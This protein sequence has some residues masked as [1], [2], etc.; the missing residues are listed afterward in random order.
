M[1]V[2]GQPSVYWPLENLAILYGTR[3]L[4]MALAHTAAFFYARYLKMEHVVNSTMRTYLSYMAAIYAGFFICRLLLLSSDETAV[5]L[6][7]CGDDIM[8]FVQFGIW[9][10]LAYLTL[11]R[12][13]QYWATDL[14]L[15]E[16]EETLKSHTESITWG[17]DAAKWNCVIPKTEIYYRKTLEERMD[18]SVELHFW[19]RRMVI[20]KRF[21]FDLLTRENIKLF[22]NE[23]SVIRELVHPNIVDFYG[24]L[25]DPPSLG[26]V[27]QYAKNG[28]LMQYLEK[29]V[30][31]RRIANMANSIQKTPVKVPR[32]RDPSDDIPVKQKEPSTEIGGPLTP[33]A[34]SRRPSLLTRTLSSLKA[35]VGSH[36]PTAIEMSHVKKEF[37]P[38]VCALEIAQGMQYLHDNNINHRDLKSP[39]VLLDDNYTALIADFGESK[40]H[41]ET[42]FSSAQLNLEEFVEDARA[43]L[44]DRFS[45]R[46]S[47]AKQ[48][49]EEEIGTPGWASPEC[50]LGKGSNKASDV[51]SFGI[52]LWELIT[53]RP[54]SVYVSVSELRQEPLCQLPGV[55]ELLNT[56]MGVQDQR[57]SSV[58]ASSDIRASSVQSNPLHADGLEA[59]KGAD[60][61]TL[62][63]MELCNAERARLLMSEKCL[64]P[65]I[66]TDAPQ[67]LHTLLSRCW[68][69]DQ[70]K[71]PTFDEIVGILS[72][73]QEANAEMLLPLSI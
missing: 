22:K 49:H 37:S 26:I 32:D 16:N 17:S 7:I 71:R 27:M 64:R 39:N 68:F 3:D 45:S 69:E 72:S 30:N 58:S 61:E 35:T 51:F 42:S 73:T 20:V 21:K 66:P 56:T 10:P 28:D 57:R 53:W 25:V 5:N 33:K 34:A 24:V 70:A 67:W 19:R 60:A 48:Q 46:G 62:V 55:K 50:I 1:W 41:L 8:R 65:P 4:L 13:C 47:S 40:I 2:P 43:S 29:N 44:S 15:D 63:L 52:I 59:P 14:D 9:G 11:K 6:G 23:A 18:I 31:K 54:P 38:F 12:N 36:S